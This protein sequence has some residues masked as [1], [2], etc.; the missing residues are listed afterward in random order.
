MPVQ[1]K[2][3]FETVKAAL[4]KYAALNGFWAWVAGKIMDIG[5]R[6][7]YDA[8][9][10][11]L[12]KKKRDAAQEVARVEKDKIVNDPNSTAEQKGKALEDYFNTRGKE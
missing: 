5:G 8:V 10:E 9:S 4:L 7:L 2:A 1:W 12:F 3:I 6:R 11:Y